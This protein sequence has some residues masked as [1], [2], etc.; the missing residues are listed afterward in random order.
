MLL[1]FHPADLSVSD[2]LVLILAILFNIFV[3]AGMPALII[4]F[5]LKMSKNKKRRDISRKKEKNLSAPQ[6]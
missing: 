2:I 3:F 4:C 6:I 1:Y 5:I